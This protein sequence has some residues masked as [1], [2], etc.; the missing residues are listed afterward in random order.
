M[1]PLTA[2]RDAFQRVL[3]SR[4]LGLLVVALTATCIYLPSLDGDYV[5][6]DI[7]LITTSGVGKST[8]IACFTRPFTDVWYRPIIAATFWLDRQA[9]GQDAVLFHRTNILIH[10]VTALALMGLLETALRNRRVAF[11]G[12]LLFAIHPLHLM[13]VAW[14]GGRTDALCALWTT[15][16]AWALV[17]AVRSRGGGRA[18]LIALSTIAFLLA[19]LTKELI[20]PCL[21][22]VPLAFR[23]FAEERGRLLRR[24]A[25]LATAPYCLAAAIA[26]GLYA[27]FGIYSVHGGSG[28]ARFAIVSLL[29]TTCYYALLLFAPSERWIHTFSLGSF[30]ALGGWALLCGALL[31]AGVATAFAAALRREPP[32]AWFIALIVLTLAAVSNLIP[33]GS[34]A[35][36][37]YR[38]A[39]AGVGAAALVAWLLDR[40]LTRADGAASRRAILLPAAACVA[41]LAWWGCVTVT[42]MPRWESQL[43]VSRAFVRYDPDSTWSRLSLCYA[44]TGANLDGQAIQVLEDGLTRDFGSDVWR[45]PDQAEGAKERDARILGHVRECEGA[46][47]SPRLWIGRLYAGVGEVLQ[48]MHRSDEALTI[49]Q[50]GLRMLP[51]DRQ[52]SGDMGTL[53]LKK[54]DYPAA[55]TWLHAALVARPTDRRTSALLAAALRGRRGALSPRPRTR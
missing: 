41:I 49:Y 16:F 3:A 8:L 24:A 9:W 21:L 53:F 50:A 33:A 1:A 48:E 27:R 12:G 44:L 18:A 13:S 25:A 38:A 46:G 20:L 7:G 15:L 54:G 28:D 52:L 17:G 34:A 2:F 47:L 37:C 40:W 30:V 39:P 35:V 43:S 6:E 22:L 29:R 26:T 11:L 23:C 14:L 4:P 31:L 19:I 45:R 36:A 55:E 5:W 32:V 42:D 10:A 51:N